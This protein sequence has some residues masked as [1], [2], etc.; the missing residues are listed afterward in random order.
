[1]RLGWIRASTRTLATLIQTRD[2]LDLGTPLLEQLATLWLLEQAENFLPARRQML[3]TRR[4]MC[5]FL[6]QQ[7]FPEW[8]FVTPEGGLSFWVDLPDRLATRF[9]ARAETVGIHL[10]TGTRFGLAG[11][12]ERNLRIPFSL[13]DTDLRAAFSTLQPLWQSLMDQPS[14]GRERKII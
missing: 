5:A 13:E 11:A 10:G 8:H 3:A 12:F 2:T 14:S 7:F 4:D 6:M 1:M 9:A